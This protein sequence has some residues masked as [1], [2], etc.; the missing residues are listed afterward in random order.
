MRFLFKPSAENG[1]EL[2]IEVTISSKLKVTKSTATKFFSWFILFFFTTVTVAFADN[3]ALTYQAKI[4]RPD[5]TALQ[6]T[7]G[8]TFSIYAPRTSNLTLP[9]CLLWSETQ[10]LSLDQ[11]NGGVSTAIGTPGAKYQPGSIPN[12]AD[13]FN[14]SKTLTG[15]AASTTCSGTYTPGALDNRYLIVQFNDGLGTNTLPAM[16]INS[17][18]FA[19]YAN[20]ANMAMGLGT[21][22][23]DTATTP[24]S[25]NILQYNGTNWVPPVSRGLAL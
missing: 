8:F 6:A 2:R 23:L 10:T 4:L 1:P 13:V 24:S 15:L 17:V 22:A 21:I 19:S 5:G 12:F 18:P 14:N 9:G 25:G 11:S 7:V 16:A 3:A 20:V